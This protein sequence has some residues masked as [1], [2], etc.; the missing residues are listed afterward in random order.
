[1]GTHY[2]GTEDEIRA[3]NTFIKFTRANESLHARLNQSNTTGGL[4]GSQFGVL[5]AL[6]HLGSMCQTELSQ[7]L[8]KSGG[9]ITMVIDNLEKNG[10]V[11]RRRS[12]QD[13]RKYEIHLTEKGEALIQEIFP[14]HVAAIMAEMSAL[15]AEEQE[16]LGQLC[17]K[18]GKR[19]EGEGN[20]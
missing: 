7:K 12:V 19:Q 11:E 2:H 15:S 17:R 20:E 1:M 18:L 10:L 5:E 16:T 8:L 14:G 9:N 3:L 13:R 6:Y 4:S